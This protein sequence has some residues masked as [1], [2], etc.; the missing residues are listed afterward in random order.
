MMGC[1]AP[2]NPLLQA[3]SL[4][5]LR[6]KPGRTEYQRGWVSRNEQGQLQVRTTGNQGSGVLSSMTQAN[7]LIVPH[8]WLQV[9][10]NACIWAF[11]SR[12]DFQLM[13]ASI[14]ARDEKHRELQYG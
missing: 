12:L 14:A 11:R 5:T 1:S 6:K 13:H 7:G 4:E 9:L 10:G 3:R 8:K 2:P